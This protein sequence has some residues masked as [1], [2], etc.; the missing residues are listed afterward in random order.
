MLGRGSWVKDRCGRGLAAWLPVKALKAEH[1]PLDKGRKMNVGVA[2]SLGN[3]MFG[4]GPVD[5]P[6][7]AGEHGCMDMM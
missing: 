7:R 4:Q 3:C 2:L 5:S 1:W 6:M